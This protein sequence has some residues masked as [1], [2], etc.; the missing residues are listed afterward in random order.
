[1]ELASCYHAGDQN[2]EVAPRYLEK[3]CT[4]KGS[5]VAGRMDNTA[6]Y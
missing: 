3:L 6:L 2:F 5:M 1:V 4:D